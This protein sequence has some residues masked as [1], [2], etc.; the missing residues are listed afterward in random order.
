MKGWKT[1]V[2]AYC[3]LGAGVLEAA[4]QAVPRPD[5]QPWLTFAATIVGAAGV[6]LLGAGIGHKIEK[7]KS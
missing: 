3:M 5:W 4:S 1:K 2:G 6:G 7:A